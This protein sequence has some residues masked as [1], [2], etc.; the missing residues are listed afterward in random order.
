MVSVMTSSSST[1]TSARPDTYPVA[2]AVM[3]PVWLPVWKMLPL[4]LAVKVTEL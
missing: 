2:V 3:T 4:A 1:V